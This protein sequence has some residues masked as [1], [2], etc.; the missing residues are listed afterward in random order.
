MP[1]TG[2]TLKSTFRALPDHLLG[3][4]FALAYFCSAWAGKL[5]SFEP[6]HFVSLWPPSGLFAAALLCTEKRRWPGLI[7]AACVGNLAFDLSN[8]KTL[9]VTLGFALANSLEA[10]SGAWLARRLAPR[11]S[12]SYLGMREFLTILVCCAGIGPALGALVGT[13]VVALGFGV[14]NPLS[15]WLLWWSADS[16]SVLVLGL[17]LVSL[18]RFGRELL[19]S[20]T[21]ARWAEYLA[22]LALMLALAVWLFN[23]HARQEYQFL[24]LPPLTWL[25]FRFRILGVCMAALALAL[26]AIL[27]TFQAHASLVAPLADTAWHLRAMQIY[28]ATTFS[29]MQVLAVGLEERRRTGLALCASEAKYRNLFEAIL[30]PVVLADRATGIMVECNQAAERYFGRTRAELLGQHQRILHP[31]GHQPSQANPR[32]V[33][34]AFP[35]QSGR[36][37]L[38]RDIPVLAAG[39][40][41]RHASIQSTLVDMDG[42][43]MLLGIFRDTTERKEAEARLRENEEKFRT[44][45]NFAYDWE[46]WVDPEGH[47]VWMAPSCER[48][49]GYTVEEFTADNGL[50]QRIVHPD[51]AE[52]FA[53]HIEEV[54]VRDSPLFDFRYR[55]I[56]KTGETVWLNHHC[57]AIQDAQGR[58]RGRRGSN[59]DITERQ[60]AQEELV[61]SKEAAEAATK[62]KSEFL[63]NMSHEIRTPLNGLLGMVQLLQGHVTPQ[64]HA[65]YSSMAYEAGNRLLILLNNILD[66]SRLEPGRES[67]T[68]KPFAVRGLFKYVL[69]SYLVAS[70]EKGLQITASVDRSVPAKLVGDEARL[71]QVLLNLVGNAVKFTPK[72]SV[73]IEAWAQPTPGNAGKAWLYIAISD[74]G[75]G[76][77][78]DKIEHIFQRF[79][80]AD[81]SYTRQYEGAGLGLALVKRIVDLMDGNILVDSKIGVGTTICLALRLD[82]P[83]AAQHG[84]AAR[85]L[86]HAPDRPLKILLADDEPIGQLGTALLLRKLGHTVQTVCNGL[87]VLESLSMND[88]D[89][90]LM[91]V[92]M[93]EM[94]GLEATRIIRTLG[95]LG[96]K[97]H[98][99]IIALT[100][101]V[102]EDE[103]GEF[104]AAG[105]DGYVGKPVQQAD[106]LRA[107]RLV[108]AK[109]DGEAS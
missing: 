80:Q 26:T 37:G 86:P 63:A 24:L 69:S 53:R 4:A 87:E 90:I 62:A 9:P 5:L 30:D 3:P 18:H 71:Q 85:K 59:N 36:P 14:D 15:A 50:R 6:S 65:L 58:S 12:S 108:G 51:D 81:A 78:E 10:V 99:P 102:M 29:T 98:I 8:G 104:L 42:R 56:K 68:L 103:R 16:L 13:S 38:S 105:M 82:L 73:H 44:V 61:R 88:F 72:G 20:G 11:G 67:L 77:P 19:R 91:D 70:Q 23:A 75:I 66:F 89:C 31:T 40:E 100:A 95:E 106:L 93:P 33:T 21:P 22:V 94:D 96:E 17:G 41:E 74:T 43:A 55:I 48:V 83:E 60:L 97:S 1:Q 45:A 39:G 46:Y 7:L 109:E 64:E 92:Q 101:Y 47:L 35:E 34:E 25:A 54:E 57:Q 28:F 49:T 2:T 79:T 76:I 27:V 32:E 52:M 84:P 107:L